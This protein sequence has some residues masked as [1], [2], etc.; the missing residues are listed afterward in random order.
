MMNIVNNNAR[1]F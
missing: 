1:L